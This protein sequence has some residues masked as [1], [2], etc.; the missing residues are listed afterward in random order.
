MFRKNVMN[1]SSG[2]KNKPSK[3]TVVKTCSKLGLAYSSAL[4]MEAIF[5]SE[6]SVFYF[7]RTAWSYIP[8]NRT[9]HNHRCQNIILYKT[10]ACHQNGCLWEFGVDETGSGSFPVTSLSIGPLCCTNTVLVSK[11][12]SFL[13]KLIIASDCYSNSVWRAHISSLLFRRSEQF[14]QLQCSSSIE[15]HLPVS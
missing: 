3:E 14:S 8:E 12:I 2:S 9:F 10:R 13:V 1:P 11:C 4:K 15:T 7:Q 6:T 5:S